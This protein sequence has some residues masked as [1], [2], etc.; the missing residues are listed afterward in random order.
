MHDTSQYN[1]EALVKELLTGDAQAFEKIYQL[2]SKRLYGHL[3][4]LVKEPEEAKEILQEV[5]ISVWRSREKID[6]DK[7]FRSYL[8]KIAENKGVDFFRKTARDKK[9]E[10][11]LSVFAS[12]DYV[13]IEE[14]MISKEK[15]AMLQQAI[16]ALPAQRRQVFSLCKLDAKSYQEVSALLGISVST[17]SDHIVKATKFIRLHLNTG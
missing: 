14:M 2:Y 5:F 13:Y 8:F 12:A 11:R 17:I 6:P 16:A 15:A 3:L 1:E 10:E 9:M 7:S 4:K